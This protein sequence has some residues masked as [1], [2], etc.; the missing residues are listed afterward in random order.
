MSADA[1]RQRGQPAWLVVV[2]TVAALGVGTGLRLAWGSDIEFKYDEHWLFEYATHP[3][4]GFS[5]FGMRS[6]LGLLNPGL[7]AWIFVA[8]ARIGGATTPVGLARTIQALNSV[9]LALVAVFAWTSVAAREREAWLWGVGLGAVNPMAVVF[10]RKIWQQSVL[11]VFSLGALVG[12]WYRDRRWG[13][14]LWGLVGIAMGQV[15]VSGFFFTG[16]FVLW[17]LLFDRRGTRWGWWTAGAFVGLAPMWPWLVYA[18]GSVGNHTSDAFAPWRLAVPVYWV[19]WFTEPFGVGL[20]SSLGWHFADFLGGLGFAVGLL[21]I[22]AILI[23]IALFRSA[24]AERRHAAP[25]TRASAGGANQTT[26]TTRAVYLGCGVLMTVS[27]LAIHRSY[28]YVTFPLE[29]VWLAWLAVGP[30][31]REAHRQL[32]RRLLAALWI[33]ELAISLSFLAYVHHNG[34]APGADYGAA[35][36][37]QPPGQIFLP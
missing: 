7:S 35:Y 33:V 9:A 27:M 17:A 3:G 12:W 2:A 14:F 32:G 20:W 1:V 29:F 16:G 6:S 25:L 30:D 23:A 8:L 22:T 19:F 24:L 36:R 10:A 13:A 28:V 4:G 26:F 11:P 37:A 18:A 15:H 31:S 5:W 21:H 34:G